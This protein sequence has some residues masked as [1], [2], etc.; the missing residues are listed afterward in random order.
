MYMNF[1]IYQISIISTCFQVLC[2][3]FFYTIA[4]S[5]LR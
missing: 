5:F 4:K 3:D 2:F 1:F